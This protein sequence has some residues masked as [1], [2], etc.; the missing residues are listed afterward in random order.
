MGRHYGHFLLE[1][2]S[3]TWSARLVA[4]VDHYVFH[5]FI[6]GA[7]VL[8]FAA[9]LLEPQ[10]ID[11]SK[12]VILDGP[13]RF[14]RIVV[15]DRMTKIN[16]QIHCGMRNVYAAI[17]NF[18]GNDPASPRRV[19]VS[20]ARLS[21]KRGRVNNPEAELLF[22]ERGFVIVHPQE[23]AIGEQVRL[24]SGCDVLAGFS[25][26]GMH[27][28]VFCRPGTRVIELLDRHG[29]EW[30]GLSTQ[31]L[32]NGLARVETINVPLKEG[33]VDLLAIRRLLDKDLGVPQATRDG[34][35][36]AGQSNGP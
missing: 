21:P 27:N 17:Q 32:C 22:A 10:G 12:L 13:K 28:T 20:R 6:F 2:L 5:P 31:Q 11:L 15:P 18:V 8:P 16:Y 23:L 36:F 1:S 26:S 7:G 4:G 19:F 33:T 14:E 24:W 30:P 35:R 9:A 3:A 29:R 25:G 34:P